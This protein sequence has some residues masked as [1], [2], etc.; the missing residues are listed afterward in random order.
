MLHNSKYKSL[1]YRVLLMKPKIEPYLTK[2]LK[3]DI[4]FFIETPMLEEVKFK[5]ASLSAD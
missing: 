1:V 5:G 2:K 3:N 4:Q